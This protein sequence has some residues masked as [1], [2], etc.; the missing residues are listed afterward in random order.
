MITSDLFNNKTDCCGCELCSL[1]CTKQIIK[2]QEDEEGFLY[3]SI[4]DESACINCRLC[5]TVCP[6]KTP[7]RES[8]TPIS[9]YGGYVNDAQSV[10]AS[11]SGAFATALSQAFVRR[12]GVVYG[13]RYSS[14]YKSIVFDRADNEGP[15][16]LFRT[17]KYAQAYKNDIYKK[18][19]ADLKEG[20]KVLFIGLPCEVSALY[21]Y[22]K[23]PNDLYTISLICHGPTSQK[24]HRQFC[25]SI[26]ELK[27]AESI[28]SLSLRYKKTGWKPYYINAHFN[29]GKD[30][31]CEFGKTDYDVAFKYMKRPS[32]S[33]C[34]YK[35]GNDK[36][37]L[38]A[39]LVLGDYH[40]VE[41][42]SHA[43][44]PWGVS[45]AT[46]LTDKGVEMMEYL[47]EIATLM[48]ISKK[49]ITSTNIALRAP[50]PPKKNHDRFV[51]V[52]INKGL[53][54]ASRDPL[55]QMEICLN[56]S[57]R[58]VKRVLVKVRDLVKRSINNI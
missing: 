40:A 13:V 17:S 24:V 50:I 14:D 46:A 3:P 10:R 44:N 8:H 18:V 38:I 47:G 36:F 43:Y 2:M 58:T 27:D 55:V 9:S 1:V 37:G 53:H 48:P 33:V 11:S 29:N 35:L 5:L 34:Q 57:K 25:Q 19:Q 4:V 49:E 54:S 21:H 39:D 16:D 56:K 28:D 7:G 42:E 26:T 12:G 22:I 6:E 31:D 23:H 52:F 15:L 45:Q 30:Y 32:C 20:Y 41:K 51:S